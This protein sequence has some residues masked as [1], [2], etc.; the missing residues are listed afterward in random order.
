MRPG[1]LIEN[2]G[3]ENMLKDSVV[4]H[5][6]VEAVPGHE[7]ELAEHLHGLLEPTRQEP[8]CLLYELHRD[9]EDAGKFMFYEEWADQA[10]LD[11]HN[12]SPHIS[13]WR[14]YRNAATPNP[15]ATQTATKW[16]IFR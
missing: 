13:A 6:Y 3:G 7:E 14:A 10:A 16:R 8:G 9:P 5:V 12:V 2:G 11:S 4:L 1:S 15:V